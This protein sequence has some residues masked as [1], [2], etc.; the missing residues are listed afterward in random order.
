[1]Q[2]SNVKTGEDINDTIQEMIGQMVGGTLDG[3]LES[4][5]GYSKYDTENKETT[6]SRN[7]YGDKKLQTSYGNVDL[8]VPRDRD[9]EYNPVIVKISKGG[10]KRFR[11]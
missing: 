8:K 1:M 5:L 10:N 11:K 4:H 9:G 2:V 3:E 6:N 7:S